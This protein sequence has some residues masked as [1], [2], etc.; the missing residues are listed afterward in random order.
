MTT[1]PFIL[2]NLLKVQPG[3][4]A[5]LLELLKQNIE[6]VVRTLDGW[7]TSRLIAAAD[8][9][10]VVIYSEWDTPG[11]IESMRADP[12]MRTYVA[13]ILELASLDSSQGAAVFQGGR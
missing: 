4:Q 8:G 5:A 3:K 2:V 6:T 9:S 7:R 10:S 11:A 13:Q 12:R 1:E